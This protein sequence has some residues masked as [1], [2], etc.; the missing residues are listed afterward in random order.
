FCCIAELHSDAHSTA[1]SRGRLEAQADYKSAIQ[2]ITNLRYAIMLGFLI[3]ALVFV[4]V[5][6]LVVRLARLRVR[7]DLP[8]TKAIGLTVL[9]VVLVLVAWWFV[10]RGKPGERIVQPQILPNPIEVLQSF[11][12]LHLEQGLVRSALTSWLRVTA[13]FTLA[14]IVA[15]PL[16]V[17]M[18]TFRPI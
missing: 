14:A 13:G 9:F 1:S 2:Q 7:A 6:T 11:V 10:T 4:T 15:V 16:G 12:P 5:L 17:Y 18:A 8:E 3:F